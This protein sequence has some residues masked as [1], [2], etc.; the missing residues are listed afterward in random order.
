MEEIL[1]EE[2]NEVK[3]VFSR[4]RK[5]DFSGNAGQA[6]KNSTYQLA[7]NI[8]MKVGSL[9]FTIIIAR[10]LM[11]QLFG[12]YSLALSTIVLFGAFT[13]MGIGSAVITFISK[14]LG[15]KKQDKAKGYVKKLL[16]WQNYLLVLV[17]LVLV[18]VSYFIARD[19][20]NKP[21]FY[22]LLVGAIYLPLNAYL[23]FFENIMKAANDFK[24][25]AVEKM[26]LQVMRLIIVPIAILLF[27]SS[28]SS[29]SFGA[30]VVV[31][32]VTVSYLP[33]LIYVVIK[34]RKGA[35]F[36]EA[37][38]SALTPKETKDLKK[39]ILP[40]TAT[41]LSGIFFGYID[42]IM[43]GH[44]VAS[45]FISYYS[46]AFNL[47]AGASGI[48]GF[49][50]LALFPIFSRISGARL[51]RIFRKARNFTLLISLFTG[52]VALIFSGII[53]KI[54]YGGAYLTSIPI[55]EFFS[56]L[57]VI[58]P[59]LTLYNNYLISRKKTAIIAKLLV[60]S[61]ALNI[62]LNFVFITYGLQFSPLYAVLGACFATI[63]SRMSYF[64]GLFIARRIEWRRGERK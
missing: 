43:L 64:M 35:H 61:T 57:I 51:E 56:I 29:L 16:K 55:L 23:A 11:P 13:D 28:S 6:I 48:I 45:E 31:A 17:S 59:L 63:I 9:V 26:I 41:S 60:A 40:L 27:I 1:S 58:L 47:V 54:V 22:A 19:Y 50:G 14:N 44:Y 5:R 8:F 21:I 15:K 3:E 36:L 30:F 24:V 10:L 12:L 2:K 34:L 62:I 25:P 20:Y 42:T 18:M 52:I 39:F 38:I 46:A 32:A 33:G 7:Q 53:V 49:A 37:K 4:I